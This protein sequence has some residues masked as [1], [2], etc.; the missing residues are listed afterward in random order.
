MISRGSGCH[1]LGYVGCFVGQVG[2]IDAVAMI[3]TA[4]YPIGRGHNII[5]L[6]ALLLYCLKLSVWRVPRHSDKIWCVSYQVH[7]AQDTDVCG[8]HMPDN[9]LCRYRITILQI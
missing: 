9:V 3:R 4:I 7:R 2:K 5:T 1:L 6:K 8:I